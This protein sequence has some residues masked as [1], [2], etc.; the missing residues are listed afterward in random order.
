MKK[1]NLKVQQALKR[2]KELR[3]RHPRHKK[4]LSV[5]SEYWIRLKIDFNA[6]LSDNNG[7]S[8]HKLAIHV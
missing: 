1:E 4:Q 7:E 5:L 8:M 6:L 2:V 3:G